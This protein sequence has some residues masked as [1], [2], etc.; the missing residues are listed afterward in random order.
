MTYYGR[1]ASI[2]GY[3]T[4]NFI[5]PTILENVALD[6]EL[7][8]T[9]IFRP[10]MSLLHMKKIENAIEFFTQTKVIIERWPSEWSRK[11]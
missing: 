2:T 9:E 5:K 8:S 11:F 4:G 10:V 3:E 1:Q 7:I 6:G